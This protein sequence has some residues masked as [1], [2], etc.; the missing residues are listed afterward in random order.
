MLVMALIDRPTDEQG[1]FLGADREIASW[2]VKIPRSLDWERVGS[3]IRLQV[4]A[5][6][7]RFVA[8]GVQD[9]STLVP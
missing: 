9:S 5:L 3:Q 4:E 6:E 1:R 8:V 7:Q 2:R